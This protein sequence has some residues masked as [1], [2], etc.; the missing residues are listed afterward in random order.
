MAEISLR[1]ML[2]T[3]DSLNDPSSN[4]A[5]S[6]S[7]R[8]RCT[9]YGAKSV[10]ELAASIIAKKH[11]RDLFG[12]WGLLGA[13]VTPGVVSADGGYTQE[14]EGGR[15][16]VLDHDPHAPKG[17]SY[18]KAIVEY[19]GLRVNEPN[20]TYDDPY[21]IFSVVNLNPDRLGQDNLEKVIKVGPLDDIDE[22]VVIGAPQTVWEGRVP[23][24][25]ITVTAG[26]FDY[27]MGDPDDVKEEIETKLREYIQNALSAIGQAY[28][29]GEE[30]AEAVLGSDI[31]TWA[32]GIFSL[33]ITEILDLGDDY[34]GAKTQEI[35]PNTL[36]RLVNEADYQASLT[37]TTEGYT[38][39][40]KLDIA[41]RE[42]DYSV[43]FR[44]RGVHQEEP[45]TPGGTQ[46]PP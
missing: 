8:S 5:P 34:I 29:A 17:T 27:D 23:G 41:S 6:W 10:R 4:E 37:T 25:G 15:I 24:T 20:E 3:D 32:L 44:V 30:E 33:G 11:H 13:S 38:Y 12:V 19:I 35:V 18:L 40:Y 22:G 46:P 31:A 39:N 16:D 21:I 2:N 43:Y 1:S 7:V 9:K 36:R 45:I 28:G 14:Y 42:G 26:A